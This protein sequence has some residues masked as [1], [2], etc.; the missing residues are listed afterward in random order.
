MVKDQVFLPSIS[1]KRHSRKF[2][3]ALPADNGAMTST[4]PSAPMSKKSFFRKPTWATTAPLTE[5]RDFFRHS[6]TVYD[7]ILREK[8]RRR[9]KNVQKKLSKV[10]VE[11]AE[12]GRENKRRRISSDEEDLEEEGQSD[13]ET[14]STVSLKEATAKTE[15]KREASVN[16]TRSPVNTRPSLRTE[17]ST[18]KAKPLVEVC[19]SMVSQVIDLDS[20]DEKGQNAPKIPEMKVPNQLPDEEMSEEEDDEY[21][22]QLKQKARERDRLRKL[23]IDPADNLRKSSRGPEVQQRPPS[24]SDDH[25]NLRQSHAAPT[26]PPGKDEIIVQILITTEIPNAKPLLVNRKVS[27]PMRQVREVWCARQNFSDEMKAKVVFTWRGKRLYDTT[28]STHLLNVLKKERHRRTEGFDDEEEEDP[29]NGRIEVK[30]MTKEMYDEASLRKD[31]GET[32]TQ[33]DNITEEAIQSRQS[34]ERSTTPKEPE[35]KVLLKA[36]ELEAFHLKVRPSTKIA[37]MMAA[38]KKMRQI[39]SGKTCWLVFDGDRLEPDSIVGD[40]EIE[41][42]DAIEVHVR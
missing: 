30:A 18:S 20:G 2:S 1:Q 23:G 15:A 10:N 25:S 35:Y 11:A 7:S 33:A 40:T 17:I 32:G 22:L 4:N 37:R 38:F 21:V 5:P 42:G 8:E 26:P 34:T 13:A 9:Q 39:D 31:R 14:A 27:Q 41:D 3:S 19:A 24:F 29:S 16:G 36:Q 6:D 12:E 28:T